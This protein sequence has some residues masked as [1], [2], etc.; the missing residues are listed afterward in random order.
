MFIVGNGL[1]LAWN[2]PTPLVKTGFDTWAIDLKFS[3]ST[4]GYGC[5]E[6][7]NN[8]LI[9]V[10]GRFEYRVV[11]SQDDMI[12]ANFGL[13]IHS[14]SKL[15]ANFPVREIVNYPYFFTRRGS[16]HATRITSSN[17][18][19]IGTRNWAYYL[20]PSFNENSYKKYKTFLMPDLNPVYIEAWRFE[21]ENLFVNKATAEEAVFLGSED[22]DIPDQD[23]RLS[24]LTPTPGI[25]F[26][27][28]TGDWS[29]RCA[30]CVPEELNTGGGRPYMEYM[31]DVCGYPVVVGG[32][33]EG[34][35]DYMI[36]DALPAVQALANNRLLLS[37]E[38]LGIGGCS[39]GGLISC[40][41]LWTRQEVFGLV[42]SITIKVYF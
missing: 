14:M 5:I 36:N 24:F 32:L 22:Y 25:N 9:P 39:L 28:K 10:G 31:R 23:G 30:G 7:V 20:P 34:Y 13:L 19:L 2:T 8:N 11:T 38:N 29:D 3:G 17:N 26:M 40:H 4:D 6:C 21:L 16:V 12:G 42:S 37:R 35:L 1:G 27:C 18:S 33:G 15:E 41:A